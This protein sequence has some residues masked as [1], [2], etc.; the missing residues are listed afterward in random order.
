MNGLLAPARSQHN[1]AASLPAFAAQSANGNGFPGQL[2]LGNGNGSNGGGRH[3]Y[4]NSFSGQG[5]GG[6]AGLGLGFTVGSSN[7]TGGMQMPL[8]GWAEEG[9]V[10]V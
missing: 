8:N 1:R 2:G 5:Q 7:E 10:G 3:Q 4:Q 6:F 9:E